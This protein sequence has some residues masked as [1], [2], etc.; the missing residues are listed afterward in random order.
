MVMAIE[1][2]LF[3]MGCFWGVE[4]LFWQQAGVLKT[5]VGYAGGHT[6]DPDYRSVCTGSTGHAE[7]VEVLY[8]TAVITL[9]SLLKLFWQSHDPTQ[10]MRQGNDVGSQYRSLIYTTSA[11]QMEQALASRTAYQAALTAAGFGS[12]TT[13]LAPAPQFYPAEDYHQRYLEKHPG[14]YCGVTATGV[15]YLM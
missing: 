4:R 5:T 7:V 2:I 6:D 10:G 11:L 9:S 1:R 12:I 3:G 15:T 13:E 8:D 14:G